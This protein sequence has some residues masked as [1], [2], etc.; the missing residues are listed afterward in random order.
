VVGRGA[1]HDAL[2]P[3]GVR[4]SDDRCARDAG[5]PAE[6][7]LDG[8]GEDLLATGH[9]HVVRPSPHG[10]QTGLD[11]ADVA[12][13][14]PA[15]R[16]GGHGLAGLG[17][18]GPQRGGRPDLHDA[19]GADAHLDAV[20][21]AP[22]VDDP[23]H[24][25]GEAVRGHRVGRPMRWHRHPAQHDA[26]EAGRVDAI[27]DRRDQRRQ[28]GVTRRHRVRVEAGEDLE[29]RARPE[30]AVDDAETGGMGDG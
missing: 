24:G 16:I 18:V 30:G 12:G 1:G 8:V 14:E 10:E 25:L 2:A 13:A 26:P 15:V 27:E 28:R 29:R 3:L 23:A 22:V 9:D 7:R 20:E 11:G 17:A 4:P 6:D 19:I 21:R 5:Q